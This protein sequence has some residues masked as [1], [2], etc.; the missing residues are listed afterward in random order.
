MAGKKISLMTAAGSLTGAELIEVVQGGATRRSTVSAMGLGA[1]SAVDPTNLTA[2]IGNLVRKE[3]F[4]YGGYTAYSIIDEFGNFSSSS[5]VGGNA[6][7]ATPASTS[8]LQRIPS[9]T[10]SFFTTSSGSGTGVLNMAALQNS[11]TGQA[12]QYRRPSGIAMTGGWVSSGRFGY[13]FVSGPHLNARFFYGY[14]LPTGVDPA[15]GAL[16]STWRNQ[17]NVIGIGKDDL[18]TNVFFITNDNVGSVTKVDT[19]LSYASLAN[20]LIRLSMFSSYT[21]NLI[22]Q[23]LYVYDTGQNVVNQFTTDLPLPDQDLRWCCAWNEGYH[24][25]ANNA[26]TEVNYPNHFWLNQSI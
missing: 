25:T 6:R 16:E 20:K 23:E 14:N 10:T 19:G 5:S 2:T 17:Q 8:W 18:D 15:L 1:T 26:N 9:R 13:T 22:R 21:Q 12:A 4:L 24:V 3:G 11:G 7:T